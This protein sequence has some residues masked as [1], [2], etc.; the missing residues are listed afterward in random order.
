VLGINHL[1][2]DRSGP[3]LEDNVTVYTGAKIIGGIHIGS[4]VI[5]GANSVVVKDSPPNAIIAGIPAKIIRIR[6]E[7]SELPF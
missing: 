6:A 1:D 5:I 7:G 4:N 3:I 2:E